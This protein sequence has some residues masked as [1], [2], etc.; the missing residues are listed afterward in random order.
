MKADPAVTPDQAAARILSAEKTARASQMAAI[1]DV[2]AA[3]GK[4]PA[5]P[6]SAVSR[7]DKPRATTPDG[8]RADYAASADLKAEF[9]SADDY[10]GYKQ[11]EA[12]GK[13]RVLNRKTA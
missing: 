2:E 7:D 11:A 13:V 12:A 9:A 8:W 1:R 5:A 3:T 10:V 6:T 4:V